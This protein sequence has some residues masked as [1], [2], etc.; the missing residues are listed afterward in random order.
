ML[1]MF[2]VQCSAEVFLFVSEGPRQGVRLRHL[3]FMR[4]WSCK[5][6]GVVCRI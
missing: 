2:P 1:Y 3:C 6:L 4:H 5:R